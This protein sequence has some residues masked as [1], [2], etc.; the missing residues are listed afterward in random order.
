MELAAKRMNVYKGNL[1]EGRPKKPF[2]SIAF[3]KLLIPLV[4]F[5]LVPTA[6]AL[7]DDPQLLPAGKQGT[8]ATHTSLGKFPQN[9]G[10]NF[11]ALFSKKN[12]VPLM[13][14]G[15]ASGILAPFDSDIRGHLGKDNESS[16]IGK[17]GAV[18]GGPA[19]V[20]PTVAGLLIAGNNS[21]NDRFHSFSYSL[22]QATALEQALVNGLKY[23]VGRPRPDE[24]NNRSFPSG[25]AATSF[26]AA[27]VLQHY[28]GTKAGVISY[29]AATFITLSRA[30][31]NKHWATD[32]TAGAVLGYIIGSSVCR[33]TGISMRVGRVTLVPIIDMQ[34]RRAGVNFI[35]DGD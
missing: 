30:R 14:G 24:S 19:V 23:A 7:D 18:M 6:Q 3:R 32:L 17:I 34:N 2:I 4:I 29:S 21:K 9:L 28:Y 15:A 11:L 31:E 27:A 35:T 10:G 12:V 25:H 5:L 16:T 8:P 13:I 33:R 22:A 20:L 1:D 26:M